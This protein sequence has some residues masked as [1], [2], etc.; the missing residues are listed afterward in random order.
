MSAAA[1]PVCF[2]PTMASSVCSWSV[3]GGVDRDEQHLD[4]S[5]ARS[6][7]TGDTVHKTTWDTTMTVNGPPRSLHLSSD[8]KTML[9][10]APTIV[11]ACATLPLPARRAR[12]SRHPRTSNHVN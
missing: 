12:R 9:L 7:N 1:E 10:L 6:F 8:A 2:A 3:I 4:A 5:L 11:V